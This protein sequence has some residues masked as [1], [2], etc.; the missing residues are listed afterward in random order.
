MALKKS[1]V[2]LLAI[3]AVAT[4]F[5]LWQLDSIPPG[6][7]PDVAL[8]GNEA[9]DSLKTGEFKVFY[10]ENNGREG[11]MMWLIA[12]SFKIFGV[13]VWSIKIVAALA[14]ILTVLGLYLLVQELFQNTKYKIQNTKYLALLA[15]FFLAASFWHTLFSRIGFRAILLPLVS[16][17]AFYFLFKGFNTKKIW[18][19][20]VSGVFFGLGF[21]TYS[22]YRLII[23][24]LPLL[25]VCLLFFKK[26]RKMLLVISYWLLV[27]FLVALPLGL[28]FLSHPQDF[29]SRMTGVSIFSQENPLVAFGKSLVSHLAMFN[30]SGDP[31]WRHNFAGSP[32]LPWPLGILF[33]IGVIIS[34][35]E[36]FLAVK[37]KNHQQLM[38]PVFLVGWF[39]VMLLP[40]VLTFEG[41]PHALRVIGVIPVVYIFVALA[42]VRLYEGWQ[43]VLTAYRN[44]KYE[45][46][47]A[48]IKG[49]S[50]L[51]PILAKNRNSLTII[52]LIFLLLIGSSEFN[53][54]FFVWAKNPNV[55]GA[56]TKNYVE[57]G[58][59]LNALPDN[60][61]KYVIVNEGG[62]PVPFPDGLAMPAQTPMFIEKTRYG[63]PRATYLKPEE[64]DKIKPEENS[65]IIF[66]K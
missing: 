36:I 14:G 60:V 8:N 66:L 43:D 3:L 47:R 4:F 1:L 18:P 12:F 31:N 61:Q 35:R 28:Y 65:T 51:A 34:I 5:R 54:Y 49:F 9:L 53:K 17:F 44:E 6:L 63:E 27:I 11:L 19:F 30:F 24:L 45:H 20:L 37:N 50:I 23:L 2:Y 40:G 64:L 10:P 48:K 57:I 32:M 26:D 16:V 22:S 41:I 25:L 33:L 42:A 46:P 62:V 38:V 39:F 7:Y 59:R 29:L 56:F 21:Y 13:S 58:E 55:E 15:S 52:S